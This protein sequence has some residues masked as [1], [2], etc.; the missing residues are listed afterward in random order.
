[1]VCGKG[2]NLTTPFPRRHIRN[3]NTHVFYI[4]RRKPK[5]IIFWDIFGSPELEWGHHTEIL[6]IIDRAGWG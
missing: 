3:K 2:Q 1:M 5:H 6:G 4:L